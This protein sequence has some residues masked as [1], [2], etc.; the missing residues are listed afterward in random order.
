[1]AVL[2]DAR[3]SFRSGRLAQ[4]VAADSCDVNLLHELVLLL[5]VELTEVDG[6]A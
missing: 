2:R 6:I 3:L 4:L 1:M 5:I